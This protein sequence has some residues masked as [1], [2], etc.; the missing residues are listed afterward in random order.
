M[1]HN[2]VDSK[3]GQILLQ[4]LR[5]YLNLNMFTGFNVHTMETIAMGEKALQVFSDIMKVCV[6][7]SIV[8]I[9]IHISKVYATACERDDDNIKDWNI[10]KMHSHVHVFS[11]IMAKG[12][13]INYD[14][15]PNEGTHGAPKATYKLLSNGKE[16]EDLVREYFYYDYFEFDLTAYADHEN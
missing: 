6:F 9:L 7:Y 1:S 12:V 4:C 10:P 5:A 3:N 8:Y 15:K 16:F 11:D 2:V 14:T 13:T